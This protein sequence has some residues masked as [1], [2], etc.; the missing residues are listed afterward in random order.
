[1]KS[2]ATFLMTTL[3]LAKAI[4]QIPKV[5]SG[6]LIFYENFPSKFVK[7]RNIAVWLPPTYDR[8]TQHSVLYM[9]DGQ[10]L[11]DTTITF[12]KQEW[13]ID[14]TLTAL[15]QEG[16]VKKTIVVGIWNTPLRRQEY[17]PA[18]AFAN[19]PQDLQ[20]SLKKDFGGGEDFRIRSDEYLSFIVKELK[21][22]I[23]KNFATF[24][25][26]RNT[27]IGGASMGGLISLY[28]ICEY[29][30][31]F[32]GAICV[33]T[34]WTGSVKRNNPNIAQQFHEYMRK[35]LPSPKKHRIYFDYGTETLDAWY[36]PYQ[37]IADQVMKEKGFDEKNWMTK[38]FVGAAH[39]E[40]SWQARFAIP[41]KFILAP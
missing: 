41:A 19:L 5:S 21:P 34:H 29:P 17:Y 38:E 40:R 4:A 31:V 27:F 37:Q 30:H 35:K 6:K 15:I 26:R 14:E 12:N 2:L 36:K 8:K 28:A 33:S 23:D 24:G 20:D 32:G 18:K 1:M 39:D 10:N 9:H 7:Q 11:F 16:T 13:G 25:N 22:F 3:I